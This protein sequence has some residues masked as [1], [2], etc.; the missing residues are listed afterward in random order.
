MK[1]FGAETNRCTI[2]SQSILAVRIESVH[3]GEFESMRPHVTETEMQRHVRVG[4]STIE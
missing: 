2:L 3:V 1:A 4:T